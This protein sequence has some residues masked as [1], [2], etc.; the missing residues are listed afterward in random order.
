[1]IGRVHPTRWAA[2]AMDPGGRGALILN[3][4]DGSWTHLNPTAAAYWK[5]AVT[6]GRTH[7]DA[8]TALAERFDVSRER[9]GADLAPLLDELRQRH[10]ITTQEP[11]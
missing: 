9:L 2:A 3:L 8:L 5:E 6:G 10:L 7:P 1:M 11:R 4:R